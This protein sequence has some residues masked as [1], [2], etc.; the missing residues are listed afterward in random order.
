MKI[1]G[2]ILDTTL[3]VLALSSIALAISA[4]YLQISFATTDTKSMVPA[5]KAG[6]IDVSCS[7]TETP[8]RYRVFVNNELFAERTF[9]WNG[10]YYLE[11]ALTIQG[12]PGEYIISCENVDPEH[13]EFKFKNMRLVEGHAV[14]HKSRLELL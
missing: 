2:K 14:L 5:I 8:P 4:I 11:E 6:D 7:W 9:I 12:A 1:L 3:V 10:D 13:G